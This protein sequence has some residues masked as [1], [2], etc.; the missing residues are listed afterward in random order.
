MKSLFN[1]FSR[2]GDPNL[3]AEPNVRRIGDTSG[4]GGGGA[5][6]PSA[7]EKAS[8]GGGG[9]VIAGDT[10]GDGDEAT[11]ST[12]TSGEGESKR[13]AMET[14]P[15]DDVCPICFENFDVPC[16]AP[17]GHWYCGTCI[18]Q[19]WNFSAALQP[20]T[21]PMCSQRITKL[22]PEASL[23]NRHEVEICKI[24]RNVGDYNRLFVGG[25]SGLMLKF[26]AIPLYMK[27]MSREMLNPDRP[28]V[29]LHEMRMVAL[30][31]AILYSMI[32]FDFL[33]IGR[34]NIVDVFDYSAFALSFILYLVGLY[35]HRRRLRNV[36]ELAHI[37][38]VRD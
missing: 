24:L 15:T 20:C 38:A 1:F 8:Y 7:A 26:L 28:G 33:Q 4:G 34:R 6:P 29:Y 35:L 3:N 22:I 14:P 11:V 2:T 12:T 13:A 17:C 21:C 32:P 23:H 27:R 30:L 37:Q 16:R 19:Y 36:R 31:L 18:L 5:E 10:D 9:G 25:I